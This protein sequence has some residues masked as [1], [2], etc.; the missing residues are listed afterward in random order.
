[1]RGLHLR[2]QVLLSVYSFLA[3]VAVN[4]RRLWLMPLA[5]ALIAVL[6]PL[7]ALLAKQL[8]PSYRYCKWGLQKLMQPAAEHFSQVE[9]VVA[10]AS[11]WGQHAN[12]R[13]LWCNLQKIG[14][15]HCAAQLSLHM[16]QAAHNLVCIYAEHCIAQ[17]AISATLRRCTQ[18][19]LDGT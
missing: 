8:L 2:V 6:S 12:Q 3:G 7:V 17:V 5:S 9:H 1:M 10:A 15:E 14:Q 11:N 13:M 18:A 16:L 4:Q 19:C